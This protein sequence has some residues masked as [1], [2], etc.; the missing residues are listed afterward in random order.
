MVREEAARL[1]VSDR[2]ELEALEA[3]VLE[4]GGLR[5][6]GPVAGRRGF[7]V[8]RRFRRRR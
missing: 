7:R 2:A 1:A 4:H 8:L 6:P 3:E 5:V